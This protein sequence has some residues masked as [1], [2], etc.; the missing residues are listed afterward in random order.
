MK[1]SFR[2]MLVAGTIAAFAAAHAKDAEAEPL[3][4]SW[5]GSELEGSATAS[6]EPYRPDG[7]TAAHR[8]LPLGTEL[9]VSYGGRQT[10]VRVN[11]RGP[12]VGGRDLDLSSGAAQEIGLTAAGAD[13]VDIRVLDG[14]GNRG[15]YAPAKEYNPRQ[16]YVVVKKPAPLK[17]APR[18]GREGVAAFLRERPYLRVLGAEFLSY[19]GTSEK[20]CQEASMTAPTPTAGTRLPSV[21]SARARIVAAAD[22][23]SPG[24]PGL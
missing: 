1:T 23:C 6:G 12:H 20:G 16:E 15:G 24:M 19:S 11:D 21:E 7:R 22:R 5:Y 8:S 17:P 10:V 13:T 18:K 4:S 3:V 14:S 2:A 9:L